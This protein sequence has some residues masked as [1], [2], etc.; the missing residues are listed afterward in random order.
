MEKFILPDLYCP[1][2]SQINKHVDV[3][4]EYSM[5]WVLRFNLQASQL[6]YQRFSKSRFFL[7]A[8]NAYPESNLDLLK[9]GND[10]LSWVFIWDDQCDMSELKKQPELL[11]VFNRRFMEILRGAVPTNQ[12]KPIYHALADLGQ[13]TRQRT[14]EK[15]FNY[16][17]KCFDQYCQGCVEEANIRALNIVPDVDA[18]MKCR[19]F[20][21]GGYLFLTVS[22]FCNNFM[23]PDILRNHEIVKQMELLTIDILAWCND[24][25]SASRE[26]SSGDVHNLV[27][28]LHYLE[29]LSL[30]Q[31]IK[32][33]TDMHNEK[34][35]A[36]TNLEEN[37]PYFGEYLDIEMKQYLSIM[38]FWIRGNLDWYSQTARYKTAEKLDLAA[39]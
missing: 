34:V 2:P 18:Y 16:F 20:S 39:C 28:I 9:I 17:L 37:L 19:R 10:W 7:L 35:R 36:L 1:F 26:M 32:R 23:L 24:I 14:S 5:E 27:L 11:N 4:E 22:E 21:V 13:R 31:A 33:A 29:K 8:A 3:L 38:H 6:A 25:F 30:N 12:E 15:W